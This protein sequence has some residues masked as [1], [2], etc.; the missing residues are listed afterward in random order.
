VLGSVLS[1]WTGFEERAQ[2]KRANAAYR[3][4]SSFDFGN[5]YKGSTINEDL[6]TYPFSI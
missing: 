6:E 5:Y 3:V 2:R 4:D 1:Q